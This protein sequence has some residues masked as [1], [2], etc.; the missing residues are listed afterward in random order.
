[1]IPRS[2]RRFIADQRGALRQLTI[3]GV[4]L[5]VALNAVLFVQTYARQAG[6]VSVQD[7]VV[8]VIGAMFPSAGLKAPS[9][10][11]TAAP[12]ASPVVV[13]GAS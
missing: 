10:P 4:V 6:D 3:G 1:M 11:P 2:R 13:T 5:S 9:S 12:G 7:A 8:S